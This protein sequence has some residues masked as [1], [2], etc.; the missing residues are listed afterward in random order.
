LENW[1]T[2]PT[3]PV[4]PCGPSWSSLYALMRRRPPDG[5]G[6]LAGR[7]RPAISSVSVVLPEPLVPIR[8]GDSSPW[9]SYSCLRAR[10]SARWPRRKNLWFAGAR[11]GRSVSAGI[12]SPLGLA[13]GSCAGSGLTITPMSG[14]EVDAL[15]LLVATVHLDAHRDGP[16]G[17]VV[18][19]HDADTLPVS[20]NCV[21]RRKKKKKNGSCSGTPPA[22]PCDLPF[23]HL[24]D[25][26]ALALQ[27]RSR[28]PTGS[29]MSHRFADRPLSL[30]NAGRDDHV[31][32]SAFFSGFVPVTGR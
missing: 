16:L 27:V 21:L 25:V 2:K 28:C 11:H 6:S 12:G 31:P 4:R 15:L 13:R 29:S 30:A 8:P 3:W 5:D 18:V 22:S 26:R 32:L 9:T 19:R 23:H 17:A 10:R 14:R 7:S 20:R 24:G 1:N